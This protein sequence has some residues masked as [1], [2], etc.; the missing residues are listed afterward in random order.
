LG[1]ANDDVIDGCGCATDT[2]NAAAAPAAPT[3]LIHSR[4]EK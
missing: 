4:R 1:I 3:V 2:G